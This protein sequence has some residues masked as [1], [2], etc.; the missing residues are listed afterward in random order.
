MKGSWTTKRTVGIAALAMAAGAVLGAVPASAQPVTNGSLSFSG[1]PGDYI[2]GGQSYAYSTANGDRLTVG[3]N[4]NHIGVSV[5]GYNGDWWS[6]DLAAPTGQTLAPGTYDR[7]TRYPFHGAGP[8][9]DLS[10]N[11]RGC[12]RLTGTFTIQNIALGPNGYVQTLDATY[13]QHCEGA[14]PALRGEVHIDNPPP[15]AQLSL[16]LAVST[17]GQASTINGRAYINGTVTCNVPVKVTVAGLVTQ[18]KRRVLIRG[19][20]STVADCTPGAPVAWSASAD[21][22][23]TTPFQRGQAEVKATA[24]ATDPQYGNIVSVDKTTVVTLKRSSSGS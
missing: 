11:G 2:S 19:S 18:V 1:D 20:Y 13:E 9:L 17:D 23:G 12:N 10:G 8:G 22:T 4:G 7:A 6:L 21:P 24:S 3:G 14:E 15:P 5:T 16:D